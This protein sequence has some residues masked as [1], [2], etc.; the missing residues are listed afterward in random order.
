MLLGFLE[1]IFGEFNDEPFAGFNI[2]KLKIN[3]KQ[4]GTSSM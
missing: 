2:A 1:T 3:N 4:N